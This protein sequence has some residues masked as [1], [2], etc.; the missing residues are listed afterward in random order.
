MI[1]VA[2]LEIKPG[3]G[4]FRYSGKVK[5]YRPAGRIGIGQA[6]VVTVGSLIAALLAAEAFNRPPPETLDPE[7]FTIPGTEVER[8][9][10]EGDLI[11]LGDRTIQVLHTPGH[12]AG[13][14]SF[15]EESTGI[16]IAGDAVYEGPMFGFH[17]DAS[18]ADYRETLQRLGE[19]VPQISIV[20]PAPNRYPLEPAFIIQTKEAM[21]Q[22]WAG[23][24]PDLHEGENVQFQFG[25]FSFA[26][27]E[28]WRDEA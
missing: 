10:D 1:T 18:A 26:F 20:Y 28:S 13:S 6:V 17:P 22:I 16:L 5:V 15:F 19:F 25:H 14:I 4:C 3:N 21:E 9:I 24:E 23:R 11:D 2:S 12:S 7:S 8:T 27:R